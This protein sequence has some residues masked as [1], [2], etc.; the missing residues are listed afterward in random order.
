MEYILET[1]NINKKYGQFN[2]LNNLNMHIPKGAIYGLIG[3][4]GAGKT[5]L[6][7]VCFL[8]DYSHHTTIN[9]KEN[10]PWKI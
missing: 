8:I 10:R 3:K 2:A 6:I 1:E 7:R 4:N 5:T 9:R